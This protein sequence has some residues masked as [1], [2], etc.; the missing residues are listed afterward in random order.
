[1]NILEIFIVGVVR[2]I[3]LSLPNHSPLL[4]SNSSPCSRSWN[5]LLLSSSRMS[6]F[7][8]LM[9]QPSSPYVRLTPILISRFILNL[10]SVSQSYEES[11]QDMTYNSR[12]SVP[13]FRVP[14][15]ASITGNMGEM[16]DHRELIQDGHWLGACPSE[17]VETLIEPQGTMVVSHDVEECGTSKMSIDHRT[18]HEVRCS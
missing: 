8:L 2:T 12:M 4:T 17:H 1:M 6:A 3:T 16:L 11:S 9:P 14:T 15:M 18:I 5:R 7:S 13:G 10:R